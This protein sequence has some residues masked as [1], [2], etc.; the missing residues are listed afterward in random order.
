VFNS[1]SSRLVGKHPGIHTRMETLS[2]S[3]MD[4]SALNDFEQ[5]DS[6]KN[7]TLVYF[8]YFAVRFL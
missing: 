6:G 8:D 2:E 3:V 1:K 4:G 7:H 5:S